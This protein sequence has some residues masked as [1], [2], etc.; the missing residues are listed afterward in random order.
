MLEIDFLLR[1][2]LNGT[3]VSFSYAANPYTAALLAVAAS[4]AWMARL[5]MDEMD[6]QATKPDIG[7]GL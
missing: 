6:R 2:L 1:S 5:E 7:R 4:M 3:V